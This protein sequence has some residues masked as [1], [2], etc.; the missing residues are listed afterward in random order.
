MSTSTVAPVRAARPFHLLPSLLITVGVA[1]VNLVVFWIASA[2]GVGMV[3]TMPVTAVMVALAS[4]V[5]LAVA[6]LA[7]WLIARGRP[8]LHRVAHWLGVIVA[9]LSM[10]AP[11]LLAH[12][13]T[14]GLCLAAMHLIAGVGWFLATRTPHAA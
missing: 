5:P 13:I 3:T 1:V 4:L 10:T 8:R 7:V 2:A 6:V 12:D 9:V 11:L 14:T